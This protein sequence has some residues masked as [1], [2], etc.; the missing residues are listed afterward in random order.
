MKNLELRLTTQSFREA[1]GIEAFPKLM[2]H[3][4]ISAELIEHENVEGMKNVL[5]KKLSE[6]GK[7]LDYSHIFDIKYQ[8]KPTNKDDFV[9]YEAIGTGYMNK[10]NYQEL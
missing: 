8:E 6:L 5:N 4:I 3:S 10:N 9:I 2:M 7:E 1:G